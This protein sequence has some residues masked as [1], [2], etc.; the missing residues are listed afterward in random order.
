MKKLL[1]VLAFT[2]FTIV[3]YSQVQ[4]FT[5]SKEHPTFP[6]QF[7]VLKVD[8]L[9]IEDGYNRTLEWI[10]GIYNTPKE[11]IKSQVENKYI[12]IEGIAKNLYPYGISK[13]LYNHV[14]YTIQFGFKENKVKCDIINVEFYDD[15][16]NRTTPG[17]AWVS[18]EFVNAKTLKKN[19]KPNKVYVKKAQKVMNYFNDLVLSLDSYLNKPIEGPVS[20]DDNW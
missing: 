12:R 6:N 5:L 16:I 15:N 9:T 1:F 4:T 20:E 2:V 19:G 13:L 3:S 8:G 11:G 10:N 14:R 17:V 7:V 18:F